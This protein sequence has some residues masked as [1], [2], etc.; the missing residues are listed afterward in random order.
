[1]QL[2][3]LEVVAP[4]GHEDAVIAIAAE[5]A[6]DWTVTALAHPAGTEP[7]GPEPAGEPDDAGAEPVALVLI[8]IL[9]GPAARQAMVDRIQTVL[10]GTKHW[11][12]TIQPVDA[13]LPAL[14][15]EAAPDPEAAEAERRRAVTA[16]R[17]ELYGAVAGGAALDS[18]FL[19]FLVLATL[20][21]ALGLVS[22]TVAVIVGAMVIAPLLGPSL[23]FALATALGDR[24][25]MLRALGTGLAGLGLAIALSALLTLIVPVPADSVELNSRTAIGYGSVALALASGAAAALSLTAGLPTTLVGVMVA[26]ALLPPAATVGLMLGTGALGPALGA[27]MLLAVNLIAVN[28]MGQLVFL[29]RGIRP[30]R[31]LSPGA[32]QKSAQQSVSLSIAVSAMLLAAI[33]ALIAAGA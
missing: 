29:M 3:I 6:A 2:K 31:W 17:E 12:L 11:R 24:R 26:V 19:I 33:I 1:M 9:S 27:A 4:R 28:L 25:L 10:A 18:N 23:A 14:E 21:A 5:A 32:T 8:R 15:P 20:V 13:S 7:I 16:T 30:H 22:D